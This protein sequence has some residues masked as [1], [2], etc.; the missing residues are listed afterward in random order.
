MFRSYFIALL[1]ILP[2]LASCRQ[3]EDLDIYQL[4]INYFAYRILVNGEKLPD[5]VLNEL[6]MYYVDGGIKYYRNPIGDNETAN[7]ILKPS[8]FSGETYLDEQGVR[9]NCHVNPFGVLHNYWYFEFPNG[10]IDTL[11]VESKK[12]NNKEG[13]QD[14]CQCNN[15]FT[16]I[17]YNGRDAVLNTELLPLVNSEPIYD[18][19]K[20]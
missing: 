12:V 6:K 1:F 13:Q 18:L 20:Q 19:H 3:K 15:P 2:M 14:V 4:D 7:H 9:V 17:K 11:Y 16:V 5:S 10:D 8:Y